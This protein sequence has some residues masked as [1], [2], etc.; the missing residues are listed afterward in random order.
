MAAPPGRTQRLQQGLDAVRRAF[1]RWMDRQSQDS[2]KLPS[3]NRA[4]TTGEQASPLAWSVPVWAVVRQRQFAGLLPNPKPEPVLD[5][6]NLWYTRFGGR[7][8]KRQP[9]VR[10][11]D[12]AR[13]DT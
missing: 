8:A 2:L 4:C 12:R 1:H 7:K 9:L 13:A 6:I 3:G 11:D 10:G 5:F